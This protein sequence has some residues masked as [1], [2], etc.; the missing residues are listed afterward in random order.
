M[1]KMKIYTLEKLRESFVILS[2]F[3]FLEWWWNDWM[4]FV[5]VVYHVFLFVTFYIWLKI[6]KS[7]HD[8]NYY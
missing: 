7:E 3:V 6:I 1:C 8:I 4:F 2:I 5:G